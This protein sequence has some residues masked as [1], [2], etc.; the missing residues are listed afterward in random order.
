MKHQLTLFCIL[1]STFLSAASALPAIPSLSPVPEIDGKPGDSGW[2][3]ALKIPFPKRK[4]NVF[5]G[6]SETHLFVAV[7]AEH[8]SIVNKVCSQVRHDSPVYDDDCL[9]FFFNASGGDKAY[10][11]IIAN[12]NGVIFD[13]IKDQLGRAFL[14]WDSGAKAK[15]SYGDDNFYIEMSIPLASL[16]PRGGKLGIAIGAYSRWNLRG[17]AV[18]GRYHHP[19]TFTYFA[20]EPFPLQCLS[21]QWPAFAGEQTAKFELQNC[22]RETMKISGV[23]G[24][25]K[26]AFQ[27]APGQKTSV[28]IPLFQQAEKECIHAVKF[29]QGK[30]LMLQLNRISMPRPLM[31]A[32]L[33]SD[34]LYHGE[35]VPLLLTINEKQTEP[36]LIDCGPRS[37]T[38]SYKGNTVEIP[39]QR[40][41]SPWR[42][43]K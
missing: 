22:S 27:L 13:H 31:N 4:G 25:Q 7:Q 37:I 26:V 15:G 12:V 3:N 32:A 14:N 5:L 11:Q 8:G 20:V 19:E 18:L 23:L 38:C 36:A 28:E 17:E 40:I 43:E 10:G 42:N 9:D 24:K 1:C 16:A 35:K 33:R 21:A 34:I 39:Y 30:R 41:D 2:K 29:Y 6:R